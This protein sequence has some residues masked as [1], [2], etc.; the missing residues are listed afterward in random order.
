M[1][2]IRS[3]GNRLLEAVEELI[4]IAR[5]AKIPAEIYHLKAAGQSNWTKLP[6]V[7][8]KVEAAQREGLAVTA[9]MYTDTAGST[10]LDAAMPPWVQEGG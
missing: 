6:E 3:E 10:G 2:H 1:S 9:N 8:Q 4:T 7:I 5:E